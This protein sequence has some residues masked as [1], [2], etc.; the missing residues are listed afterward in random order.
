MILI[1]LL[2]DTK[3]ISNNLLKASAKRRRSKAQI[4][5]EKQSASKQKADVEA[6]LAQMD[7]MQME[8]NSLKQKLVTAEHMYSQVSGMF[9]DGV[10]KQGTGGHY[11]AVLDPNE[12]E[13]IRSTNAQATKAKMLS[14]GDAE[15]LNQGLD[16]LSD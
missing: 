9:E 4:E 15:I 7:H 3:G 14:R 16:E 1:L 2:L 5:E 6:R 8:M 11:E 13:S 12:R 10:L